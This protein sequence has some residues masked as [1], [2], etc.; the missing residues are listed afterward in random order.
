M[1]YRSLSA[2]KQFERL[3]EPHQ[4]VGEQFQSHTYFIITKGMIYSARG[5]L[6]YS[7]W[8][9]VFS[10]QT[11]WTSIPRESASGAYSKTTFGINNPNKPLTT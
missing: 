7:G 6:D 11:S 10:S 3:L 4:G 9:A 5:Q 8:V 1:I 2:K